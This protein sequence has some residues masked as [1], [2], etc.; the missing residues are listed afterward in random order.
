MLA[1]LAVSRFFFNGLNNYYINYRAILL[2]LV[3]R[4]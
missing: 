3:V 1:L 2:L 4:I